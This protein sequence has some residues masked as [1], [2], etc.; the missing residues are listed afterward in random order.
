[1]PYRIYSPGVSELD[2]RRSTAQ[3]DNDFLYRWD[4]RSLVKESGHGSHLD[5]QIIETLSDSSRSTTCTLA[6]RTWR[7]TIIPLAEGAGEKYQ[8][9]REGMLPSPL[10]VLD[11]ARRNALEDE[12]FMWPPGAEPPGRSDQAG[13][14]GLEDDDG[15]P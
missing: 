15:R 4:T 7:C 12:E 11:G 8:L 3:G 10:L 5:L 1:M 9:M 14:M 13:E 2:N 6:Y